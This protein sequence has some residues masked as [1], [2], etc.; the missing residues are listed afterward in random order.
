MMKHSLKRTWWLL[1]LLLAWAGLAEADTPPDPLA[2]ATNPCGRSFVSQSNLVPAGFP[3]PTT[4]TECLQPG[5]PP[6]DP[7]P[8]DWAHAGPY[9]APTWSD[10]S[11][12]SFAANQRLATTYYFYWYD[13]SSQ[14]G[15]EY[16]SMASGA[17]DRPPDPANYSFL[18]PQTHLREFNDMLAAGLDF[19]LPVY[20]GEPGHPGRTTDETYPHYWSTEGIPAMV[21]AE[22][23]LAAG[24]QRLPIGMFYD[25]T[26]LANADLTTPAGKEYFYVNVRDFF[27]RIPPKY[28]A[29]IGGKPLIWLYDTLWISKFHQSSLDYL[30][31][32]FA[33]DFGGLRPYIVRENQWTQSKGVAPAQTLQSDGLYSW[34]AAPNGYDPNPALSVAEVGPGFRNTAYCKGGPAQNC[35]DINRE[36]G[37]YYQRQLQTAVASNHNIMA[38]ETW[39]EFSEGTDVAETVQTG[40]RYIDLTKTYAD[41]FR[42][43]KS[44]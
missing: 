19:A 26:I 32:R 21:Q 16:A 44:S 30:S 7:G 22:D 17:F 14:T 2:P 39:N 41:R 6:R 8:L 38:V 27:S 34:G 37:A 4:A 20:W 28:W 42:A 31:D 1:P 12:N 10:F 36:N 13:L 25:T 15:D 29:A 43:T 5:G 3:T 35:Y 18:L 9:I 11:L 40:R 33:Q 23:Q 24:G